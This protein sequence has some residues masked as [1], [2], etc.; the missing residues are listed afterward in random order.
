[1]N[2]HGTHRLATLAGMPTGFSMRPAHWRVAACVVAGCLG[3]ALAGCHR[4]PPPP[5]NITPEKALA[6]SLRLTATGDFDGLMKNRLPPAAYSRWRAEWDAAHAARVPATV[7]QEQQFAKIMQQLTA[8]GA[9]ANLAARLKP[10]LARMRGGS[11]GSP[12]IL[13]GIVE[14]SGKAMITASPQLGPAQ[15]RLATSV[16]AALIEWAKTTDFSDAKKAGKA[17]AIVCNTARALHVQTLEQWRALD[18]AAA[19]QRYGLVWNGLE[20]VLKLYG[21]DLADALADAKVTAPTRT[22]DLATVRLNLKLAGQTLVGEWTMRQQDGHW[23]DTALLDAWHQAHPAP[24]ASVPAPAASVGRPAL[25]SPA[26]TVS[27]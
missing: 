5:S 25:P 23:Y 13:A 15:K 17:I 9:E 22:D 20:G 6:T 14:A 12:P 4:T 18:Y 19:M 24:A 1:M 3:L 2:L 11:K 8:Q 26:A 10:E 7:A 16:L 27:G 21:L